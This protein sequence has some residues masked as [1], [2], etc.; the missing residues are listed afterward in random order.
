MIHIFC[1]NK[2]R[3]FIGKDAIVEMN[4]PGPIHPLSKWNADLFNHKNRKCILFTNK[5]TL[6]CVVRQNILKKDLKDLSAF[7]INAL[8]SQLEEENVFNNPD[9]TEWFHQNQQVEYHSTDNDRKVIG[10]M[11]DF[12]GNIA[13]Y[14]VNDHFVKPLTDTYIAKMTNKIPMGL[15]RYKRPEQALNAFTNDPKV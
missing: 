10:S 15:L 11:N 8:R 14:Y 1:S 2:L 6:F 4:D 5:L 12:L 3:L 13:T 9:V 7:F